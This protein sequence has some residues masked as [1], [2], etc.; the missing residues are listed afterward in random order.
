MLTGLQFDMQAR[1]M[2]EIQ[3]R[4]RG[5]R[6]ERV[7]EAMRLVPRHEFVPAELESAAYDDRPLPIG[8]HET[9][10]QPYMVAAMTEA[11]G[12]ASGEKVLEIGA[13]SGYQAAILAQLGASVY[14][15]E[16]N[17]RLADMASERL[18]RLGYRNV[19]VIAGDGSEG[20][21]SH[22]PYDVIIVSAGTPSVSPH[23]IDQLAERG[24]L[25][26][27]VGDRNVQELLV[28]AKHGAEITTQHLDRCQFVPLVG[29]G[30][31][32]EAGQ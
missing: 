29:K 13:G 1:S 28:I 10:S 11:A 15:V 7:L 5:I 25:V 21:A 14:A 20:L 16:L 27:P 4:A 26:A 9:I 19:E 31:W 22:A 32:A 2:V 18:Q 12:V 24:R 8:Q 23:L 30:G 17:I 3:L 6:D